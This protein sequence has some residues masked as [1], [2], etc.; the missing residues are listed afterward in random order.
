MKD[1][2]DGALVPGAVS[3]LWRERRVTLGMEGDLV[4]AALYAL[5]VSVALRS[6]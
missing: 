2:V 3:R 4:V 5:T 1:V 6:Q